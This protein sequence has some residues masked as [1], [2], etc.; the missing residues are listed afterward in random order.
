MQKD[1]KRF[2]SK[3]LQQCMILRLL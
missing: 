3:L 1:K 2:I